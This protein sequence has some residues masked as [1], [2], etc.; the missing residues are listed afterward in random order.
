[1]MHPKWDIATHCVVSIYVCI[2]LQRI[3]TGAP[4]PSHVPRYK[5]SQC[6]RPNEVR[7]K[8]MFTYSQS[9]IEYK[10]EKCLWS[11]GPV[12]TERQRQPSDD[13]SDWYCSD[14]KQWSRPKM[15]CNPKEWEC[16]ITT[17]DNP[18]LPAMSSF[19]LSLNKPSAQFKESEESESKFANII[20]SFWSDS[21]SPFL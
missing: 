2:C 15:G 21:L 16:K 5:K 11:L 10:S 4:S 20:L 17:F 7:C 1:M 3:C 18:I 14:W 9:E 6:I 8:G 13:A 19:S 12:Y